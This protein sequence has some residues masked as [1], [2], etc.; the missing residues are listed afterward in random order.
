MREPHG[1]VD[2]ERSESDVEADAEVN[3]IMQNATTKRKGTHQD[4]APAS[5][6]TESPQDENE[7]EMD[8]NTGVSSTKRRRIM[9]NREDTYSETPR[10][11]VFAFDART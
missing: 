8:D 7:E 6:S 10:A 3:R 5:P 2:D 4:D 11:T 1:E 9:P